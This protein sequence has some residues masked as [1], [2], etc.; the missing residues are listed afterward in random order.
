MQGVPQSPRAGCFWAIARFPSLQESLPYL[1]FPLVFGSPLPGDWGFLFFW[2]LFLLPVCVVGNSTQRVQL[3]GKRLVLLLDPALK[4]P[5]WAS[6]LGLMF[7][8]RTLICGQG[9][10]SLQECGFWESHTVPVAPGG[11]P[12]LSERGMLLG[13]R[14]EWAWAA[15]QPLLSKVYFNLEKQLKEASLLPQNTNPFRNNIWI[16]HFFV[17]GH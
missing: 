16:A 8:L 14:E 15:F 17:L 12:L 13:S 11:H 3:P 7:V 9:F 10:G 5:G 4:S 1:C 2:F 6:G